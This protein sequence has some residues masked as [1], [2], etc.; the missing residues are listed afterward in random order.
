MVTTYAA[1]DAPRNLLSISPFRNDDLCN[2]YLVLVGEDR[3]TVVKFTQREYGRLITEGQDADEP[4]S[5]FYI[6][7]WDHVQDSVT[8][9]WVGFIC[10]DKEPSVV[11]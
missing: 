11:A 5:E 8:G 6:Y 9:D 7:D 4:G 1:A 3:D 2:D 10:K